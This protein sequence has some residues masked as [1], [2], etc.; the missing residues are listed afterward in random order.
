MKWAFFV[1]LLM[2]VV[3]AADERAKASAKDIEV[4]QRVAKAFLAH[5]DAGNERAAA[6]FSF[7]RDIHD[8]K[9]G[10]TRH[11]P[12]VSEGALKRDIDHLKSFGPIIDRVLERT[13][14]QQEIGSSFPR[15]RYVRFLYSLRLRDKTAREYLTIKVDAPQS[16]KVAHY[17][18][19]PYP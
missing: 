19:P 2:G 18:I 14:L 12:A 10:R 16:G 8:S 9:S 1:T 6:S 7:D 17:S 15:G 11:Y 13:E 3:F 5:I 4:A